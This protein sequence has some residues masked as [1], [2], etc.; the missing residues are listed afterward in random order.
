[1]AGFKHMEN[2][3]L[4]G[5]AFQFGPHIYDGEWIPRYKL[6]LCRVC[7]ASNWDGIGPIF[8]PKFEAHLNAHGID[9]PPRN[10]KGWYPRGK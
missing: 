3:N 7:F 10:S 4:C 8:E 5:G 6:L 2:C 1:M 9:F